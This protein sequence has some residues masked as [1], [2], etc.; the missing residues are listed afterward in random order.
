MS[1]NDLTLRRRA[2]RLSFQ[3]L[4]SQFLELRDEV[5]RVLGVMPEAQNTELAK[6]GLIQSIER[7]VFDDR[8]TLVMLDEQ[9]AL[10]P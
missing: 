7:V 4:P 1:R 9:P 10:A 3:A 6:G 2:I 5:L 8:L